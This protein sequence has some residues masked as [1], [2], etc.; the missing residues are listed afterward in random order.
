[1]PNKTPVDGH[2][3]WVNP[4]EDVGDPTVYTGTT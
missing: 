1:M 2:F 4:N 3:E